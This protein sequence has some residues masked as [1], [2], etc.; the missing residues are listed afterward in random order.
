MAVLTRVRAAG[1]LVGSAVAVACSLALAGRA[2][3]QTVPGGLEY[4]VKAAYLLNFTRYVEWPPSV[5]LE[6]DAALNLC[7]VGRDPFGDVLDRTVAGR[8]A[9]GR[10]LRV[11]RPERPAGDVCHVT[12]IGETTDAAREAW[13]VALQ[14]APTLTVGEGAAFAEAG[15]M[16]AFV[17]VGETVRFEI[18]VDAV[19]A[20]GLRISSRMLTLATRLHPQRRTP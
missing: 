20:S 13:M 19:R 1:L 4:Q 8:R 10:R 18:N 11:L 6:P 15:G 5:F 17:I 2:S 9:R 16:I 3:A 14:G 12:F 7:L